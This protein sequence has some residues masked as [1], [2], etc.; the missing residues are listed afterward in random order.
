MAYKKSSYLESIG[1][2]QVECEDS[3]FLIELCIEENG[4][5]SQHLGPRSVSELVSRYCQQDE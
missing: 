5:D 1:C 4:E 3:L 2:T